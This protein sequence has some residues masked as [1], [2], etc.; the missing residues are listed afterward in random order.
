M[1]E[2]TNDTSLL[3]KKSQKNTQWGGEIWFTLV[4]KTVTVNHQNPQKSLAWRL[5]ES[6]HVSHASY[7]SDYRRFGQ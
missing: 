7:L 5:G 2:R 4:T 6:H 1:I 3:E